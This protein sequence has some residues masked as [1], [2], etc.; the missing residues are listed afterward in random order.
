MKNLQ[1]TLLYLLL[2]IGTTAPAQVFYPPFDCGGTPEGAGTCA[3][4]CVYCDLNWYYGTNNLYLGT[5]RTYCAQ[6][7]EHN[8]IWLA[9]SAGSTAI[10]FDIETYNCSQ[11]DGLQVAILASCDESALVC[12]SGGVGMGGATLDIAYDQYEVGKTYYMLIDGYDGDICDFMVVVSEGSVQPPPAGTPVIHE[13]PDTACPGP[14]YLYAADPAPFADY[15]YWTAPAGSKFNN[16]S[17]VGFN[18]F[19][20]REPFVNI[21]FGAVSGEVCVV[22]ANGCTPFSA[23]SCRTVTVQT[24]STDLPPISI[25]FDDL[26]Y[27]W[28]EDGTTHLTNAGV[29]NL[30]ATNPTVQGCD[31][32]VRQEVT[33][34]PPGPGYRTGI[35]YR[36]ANN[37][38]VKDPGENPFYQSVVVK[39]S[40]GVFTNSAA[41]NGVYSFANQAVG[42]TLR[43][44]PPPGK[45]ASPAFHVVQNGVWH[46]YD[47]GITD[48]QT[49]DKDI[50]VWLQNTILRPGFESVLTIGCQNAGDVSIS[51]VEVT[52]TLPSL[53]EFLHASVA[54]FS[55]AGNEYVWKFADIP[56]GQ[57]KTIE[58]TLKTPSGTPLGTVMHLHAAIVPLTDDVNPL[59]NFYSRYETVRG[60]YDPN[61]K[62]V[63]PAYVTPGLLANGQ[64]FEYTIRFQNTGNFPADFVRIVDTLGDMVDPATFEL[65]AS[66]HPCTWKMRGA[67]VVEFMF[68]DINLPDSS[69]NEP[70]SHGFVKFTVKPKRNLPL[71]TV[72]RN[73]CDIY[74]DYNAPVRTNTAGTQVVYFIPG[75]GLAIQ[76]ALRLRPNPAA[77]HALCDWTTPAPASGLIRVFDVTG[78]PR[79]EIPVQEGQTSEHLDVRSLQPGWYFVVLEAGALILSNRLVVVPVTPL[80]WN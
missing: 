58:V 3:S 44:V 71:G 74:F 56:A 65:V 6:L 2:F 63:D 32:T 1:K 9:F 66:S 7:V 42:D 30:S 55:I 51:D 14:F 50:K 27:I 79:L 77:I 26:P 75:T 59:N 57:T 23:K 22:A 53:L 76:D 25:A 80:G 36:D 24:T 19:F 47:F 64:P 21:Q 69:S 39:S 41:I 54:P 67:G 38:G 60:S 62:T 13:G 48:I 72:I 78:L 4:S 73:F 49:N 40:T 28:P 16:V 35:I 12:N 11:G 20:T 43:V 8:P 70:A 10:R 31:S 29:F 15:Y 5:G 52:V 37:N 45:Q 61:D 34:L 18:G 33:V 68:G 17:N 46:G